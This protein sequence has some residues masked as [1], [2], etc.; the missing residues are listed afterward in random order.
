MVANYLYNSDFGAADGFAG[1]AADFAGF[2]RYYAVAVGV[3]GKVA[4]ELGAFAGALGHA[5][6]TD[7]NLAGGDFLAAEQLNTE[8]LALAVAGIFGGT[9]CFN[10]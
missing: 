4:A 1:E 3:D 8:A 2:K 5:D 9:A 10:V 7:N 6:L